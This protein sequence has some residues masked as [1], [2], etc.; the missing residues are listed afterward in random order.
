VCAP[1]TGAI[2]IVVGAHGLESGLRCL[3][4]FLR[5]VAGHDAKKG[6]RI[7]EG[8]YIRDLVPHNEDNLK[9]ATDSLCCV[10]WEV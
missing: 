6:D 1:G 9:K 4:L 7:T 5:W 2:R 10:M 8:L 3:W